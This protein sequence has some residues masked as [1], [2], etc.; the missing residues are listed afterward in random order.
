LYER[1]SKQRHPDPRTELLHSAQR[2]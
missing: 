2:R 1:L